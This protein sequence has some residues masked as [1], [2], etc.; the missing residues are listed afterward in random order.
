MCAAAMDDYLIG[1]SY[2]GIDAITPRV[3]SEELA[4]PTLRSCAIIAEWVCKSVWE[5]FDDFPVLTEVFYGGSQRAASAA[6]ISAAACAYFTRNPLMNQYGMYHSLM[7]SRFNWGR[8]GFYAMDAPYHHQP[9]HA[10]NLLGES[11][12]PLELRGQNYPLYNWSAGISPQLLAFVEGVHFICGHAYC[13]NP[14]V[15]VAFADPS[16]KVDFRYIIRE[17][18]RGAVKEFMPGG[19]RDVVLPPH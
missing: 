9:F 5:C 12:E 1:V 7:L 13:A 3:L 8:L 14:V 16:L 2:S 15:K 4:L 6:G 10:Y 11:G 19:E 17:W 18:A